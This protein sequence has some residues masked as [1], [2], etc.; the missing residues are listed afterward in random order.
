[1]SPT[2]L[3]LSTLDL[4]VKRAAVVATAALTLASPSVATASTPLPIVPAAPVCQGVVSFPAAER[5][6]LIAL[7][8]PGT[9][10]GLRDAE[11]R[12]NRM[13]AILT[14]RGDRRGIFPVFY[15]NILRSAIPALESGQ[16]EYDQWSTAISE[17]F[18]RRYTE[19][20]HAHLTGGRVTPSWQHFY[21]LA[22]DCRTSP[23][24]VAMAALDAHLVIDFPHS[25]AETGTTL[26]HTADFFAFGDL[27]RDETVGLAVQLQQIYG[28][29]LQPFFQLYFFGDKLDAVAGRGTTTTLLFQTIRGLSLANGL[30]LQ[31]PWKRLGTLAGMNVV[32]LAA[33]GVS[34]ALGRKLLL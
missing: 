15:R 24:R 29:N 32:W 2:V 16:F 7:S 10:T 28:T 34:D 18:Y 9:L 30:A 5:Q 11:A 26:K 21:K 22:G 8:N 33:E 12:V 14:A 23:G 17:S 4:N 20:F 3:S 31:K 6:E 25:V 1:M 13:A 19:N 27:L